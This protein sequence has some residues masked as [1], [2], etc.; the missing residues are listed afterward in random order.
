MAG[1]SSGGAGS[2]S[3]P[4]DGS[5]TIT[6]SASTGADLGTVT[7]TVAYFGTITFIVEFDIYAGSG[8]I[9]SSSLAGSYTVGASEAAGDVSF[10]FSNVT[11]GDD[12]LDFEGTLSGDTITGTYGP[13][14]DD[15][16]ANGT[17]FDGYTGTFTATK[18]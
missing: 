9:P 7:T 14:D 12:S 2:E 3:H 10:S 8:T 13:Y 4:L 11:S 17:I 16:P 18:N 5:W 1:C 15:S 6:T